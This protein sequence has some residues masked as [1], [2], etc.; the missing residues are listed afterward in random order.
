MQVYDEDILHTIR[1]C[2][3]E[4]QYVVCPHTAAALCVANRYVT[5]NCMNIFIASDERGTGNEFDSLMFDINIL[6]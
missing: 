4:N 5:K 1:Q 2:H 3:Q 6:Y